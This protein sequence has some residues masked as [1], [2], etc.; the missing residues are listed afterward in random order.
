MPS[1]DDVE[2]VEEA[3][4]AIAELRADKQV[5]A[6]QKAELGAQETEENA[7]WK[8]RQAGR[9]RRVSGKGFFGSVIASSPNAWLMA[10]GDGL[11]RALEDNE[12]T[13]RAVSRARSRLL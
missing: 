11:P 12:V 1:A 9:F 4:S 3:Q 10:A 5:L 6:A 8:Q 2:T 7:R 13:S